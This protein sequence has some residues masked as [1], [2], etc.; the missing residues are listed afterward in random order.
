MPSRCRRKSRRTST[1]LS[2]SETGFSLRCDYAISMLFTT[3]DMP[4]AA[5]AARSASS[6]S[7]E[8][9]TDP[10]KITFESQISTQIFSA[11]ISAARSSALTIWLLTSAVEIGGFTSIRLGL[12]GGDTSPRRRADVTEISQ[13]CHN[14]DSSVWDQASYKILTI[15]PWNYRVLIRSMIRGC[16]ELTGW[17]SEFAPTDS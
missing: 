13:N 2:C 4:G 7:T 5:H 3:A 16:R 14:L 15:Y 10:L 17:S 12:L 11:S 1:T 9:L 6:R 8:D